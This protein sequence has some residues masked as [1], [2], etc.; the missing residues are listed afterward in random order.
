MV[1]ETSE[2]ATRALR[3]PDLEDVRADERRLLRAR[4]RAVIVPGL[5]QLADPTAAPADLIAE[6]D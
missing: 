2:R 1:D 6:A 3:E 4:V 5:E